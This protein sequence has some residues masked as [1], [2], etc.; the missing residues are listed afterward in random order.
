MDKQHPHF[1]ATYQ[2]ARQPNDGFGVEANHRRQVATGTL[3]IQP[4]WRK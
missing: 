2:L 3:R 4:I 1:G